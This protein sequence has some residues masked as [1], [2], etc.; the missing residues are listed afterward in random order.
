MMHQHGEK[1]MSAIDYAWS[2]LKA[3]PLP[4]GSPISGAI[5]DRS[6]G[7][8]GPKKLSNQ[9]ARALNEMGG[10]MDQGA[11][12]QFLMEHGD[13]PEVM[14]ML[15]SRFGM[16]PGSINFPGSM[17]PHDPHSTMVMPD[18]PAG[19]PEMSMMQ[20]DGARTPAPQMMSHAPMTAAEGANTPPRQFQAPP[21]DLS[22]F[23][24]DE[25]QQELF[26]RIQG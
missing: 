14:D 12:K 2:V 19:A 26:R 10:E 16:E 11:L 9:M 20:P 24:T 21:A 3:P 17:M 23:I 22:Q 5:G 25:L 15:S 7:P 13:N 4:R 8:A 1:Q 18:L 6:F